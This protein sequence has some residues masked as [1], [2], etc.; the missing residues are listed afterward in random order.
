M[1]NAAGSDAVSPERDVDGTII[2]VPACQ[3]CTSETTPDASKKRWV[4]RFLNRFIAK[5]Y[6]YNDLGIR[7]NVCKH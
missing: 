4:L 7:S 1:S 3:S 6:I 5:D 2:P